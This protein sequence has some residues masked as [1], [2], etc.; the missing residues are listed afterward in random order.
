MNEIW[1]KKVS[2]SLAELPL[3]LGRFTTRQYPD[4][5]S[6]REPGPLQDDVPVFMFHRVQPETFEEQLQFLARNGY[7]TL[8]LPAFVN[9]LKGRYTL[10]GPSVLLTFDDGEKS[11]YH[12][13]YPLLQKYGFHGAAFVIPHFVR[14][15]PDPSPEKGMVSWPELVEM[16]HSGVVDVQ[17]HGFRHDLI[18]TAPRREDFYHPL[19]DANL[20]GIDRPWLTEMGEYTNQLKYGTPLF[21]AA[22][23]YGPKPRYLDDVVVRRSCTDWVE[24]N[25]GESFFANPGW[26]KE[27]KAFYKTASR[28]RAPAR[29]EHPE[30][31]AAAIFTDIEQARQALSERLDKQVSHL[32]LPHGEGSSLTSAMCKQAGCE[33]LFWTALPR[34]RTNRPGDSPYA[35]CR[36]KDD[37]LLRLPGEGRKPLLEILSAKMQR[38]AKTLDL[39]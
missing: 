24:V 22:S 9:F 5:V 16:E 27:M 38:R 26:R 2:R 17:S 21:S 6:A 1:R 30:E 37:Y 3:E 35:V 33:S 20:L 32:C 29:F 36:L 15:E 18:F 8:T 4:F 7:R 39:Y 13:A 14:A 12:T 34:R 11:L 28:S 25:G 10:K 19:W 23:R 31:Q